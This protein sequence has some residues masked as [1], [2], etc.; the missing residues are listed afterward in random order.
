M[1]IL[2]EL[3]FIL[4]NILLFILALLDSTVCLVAYSFSS[5]IKF[6]SVCFLL[7]VLLDSTQWTEEP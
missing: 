7:R 5:S 4:F 6:L 3:I 2:K 1:D